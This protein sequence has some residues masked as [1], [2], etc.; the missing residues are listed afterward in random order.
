MPLNLALGAEEC[1][2]K[3]M[4]NAIANLGV[5][6]KYVHEGVTYTVA[7]LVRE[8]DQRPISAPWWRG[9]QASIVGVD[10]E[11][12][13]FIHHCSGKVS[14]RINATQE[15]IELSNSLGEFL[16]ALQFDESVT[17]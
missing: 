3:Q 7:I 9:K 14:L 10:I 6:R 11:G 15:E 1:M 16:N 13:F 2:N 12:N 17:P 4:Q 8:E 5:K